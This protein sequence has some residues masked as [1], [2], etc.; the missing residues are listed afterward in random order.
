MNLGF[1]FPLCIAVLGSL[2]SLTRLVIAPSPEKIF[3][4][5]VEGNVVEPLICTFTEKPHFSDLIACGSGLVVPVDLEKNV[6]VCNGCR[7]YVPYPD[8]QPGQKPMHVQVLRA[9]GLKKC[10]RDASVREL[11][12]I[13][14]IGPSRAALIAG[15]I[16]SGAFSRGEPWPRGVG[17]KTTGRIFEYYRRCKNEQKS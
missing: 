16:A 12:T 17:V 15:D 9:L 3:I 13:P 4:A 1:L 7:A 6:E 8:E 11:S 5:R 14:G 10:L 2:W